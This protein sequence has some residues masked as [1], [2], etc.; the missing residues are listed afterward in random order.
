[1]YRFECICGELVNTPI[2]RGTCP[3]CRRRFVLDWQAEYKP[4]APPFPLPAAK[5]AP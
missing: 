5:A 3:H 4:L 2:T 1:M